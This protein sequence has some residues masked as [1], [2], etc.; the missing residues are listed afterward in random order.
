MLHRLLNWSLQARHAS[1]L[2]LLTVCFTLGGAWFI[3]IVLGIQP[4]PLC[5]EQR[6]PYYA[7]L[8]LLVI[9][10]MQLRHDRPT[11]ARISGLWMIIL[12]AFAIA[13]GMGAYHAGVEWG[14]WKGPSDC[15]GDFKPAG[16]DQLLA[17]L[18]TVKVIRCDAVAMRIFGLSLAAWN[19]VIASCLVVF[20]ALSLLH[21]RQSQ[22]AG[23]T[24][25][26]SSLSQ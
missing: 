23:R 19:A 1:G 17:Q 13:G 8:P 25:G 6:L 24:Y 22:L 15:T 5:L 26:S 7:S 4:C 12:I 18:N 3:Q 11:L 20:G 10:I 16:L 2:M 9:L 21:W 14:L